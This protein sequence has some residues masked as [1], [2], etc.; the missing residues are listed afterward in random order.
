MQVITCMHGVQQL[1]P[2]KTSSTTVR[3]AWDPEA[4]RR[5][6]LD[7]AETVFSRDGLRGGT[8]REIAREAGVN[9]VTIFR[10]FRSR[11]LLLA[12]VM[13]RGALAT[14]DELCGMVP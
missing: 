8:T 4:T 3:P 5:R 6:I 14:A 7:A 9:E 1:G 11:D 13:D 10:H 2:R 12:A